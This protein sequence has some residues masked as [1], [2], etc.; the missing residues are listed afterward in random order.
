MALRAIPEI[1]DLTGPVRRAAQG[2]W[3]IT[4]TNPAGL[5]TQALMASGERRV[6]GICDTPAALGR[7]IAAQLGLSEAAMR[8]DYVGL[9]NLGW[10]GAFLGGRTE[11]LPGS[12]AWRGAMLVN[13]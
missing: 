2:A 10:V 9:D 13:C 11:L 6:I 7:R 12:A 3:I 4:F 1:V 5:I 8:L